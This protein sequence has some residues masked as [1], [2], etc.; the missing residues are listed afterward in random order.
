MKYYLDKKLRNQILGIKCKMFLVV[1]A[2]WIIWKLDR[3][4]K[5]NDQ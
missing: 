3:N 1:K 5:Q 4:E 2:P